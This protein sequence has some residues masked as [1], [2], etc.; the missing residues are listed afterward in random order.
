MPLVNRIPTAPLLVILSVLVFVPTTFGQQPQTEG[1][2]KIVTR[3]TPDY[4]EMAWTLNLSG[5]VKA[6]A[7]VKPN[8]EVKSVNVTGGHPVL[9]RAVREAIYHWKWAPS[10]HETRELI[11]IKF[12]RP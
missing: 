7:V 8:G 6:E 5:S 3:V 10:T 4:P 11:E 12:N 2:R 1:G 9:V